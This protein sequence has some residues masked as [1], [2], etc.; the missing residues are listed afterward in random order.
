ETTADLATARQDAASARERLVRLLGVWDGNLDFKLPA[1]L[2]ALPPHPRSLPL[3][4]VDAI[5]HR[6]DLQ[7]A[8]LQLVALSKSLDLA[9][10]TR[11]VT[12][13]DLAGIDKRIRDPGDPPRNERGFDIEFQI[14]IFDGGEVRVRQAVETYDRAFNRLTEQAVN[15]RSEA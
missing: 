3:I 11:F 4:E 2:P 7:I 5:G 1:R 13:L 9:E 10:A 14:P 15:V 6:L 8:R 12:L